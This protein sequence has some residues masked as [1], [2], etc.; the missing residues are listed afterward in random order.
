MKKIFYLAALFIIIPSVTNAIGYPLQSQTG[1]VP[2]AGNYTF[3]VSGSSLSVSAGAGTA[4]IV[5]FYPQ[6]YTGYSMTVNNGEFHYQNGY[7]NKNTADNSNSNMYPTDGFRIAGHFV[8]PTSASGV[9]NYVYDGTIR[10]TYYFTAN[11]IFS[12]PPTASFTANGSHSITVNVGDS[13]SYAWSSTNADKFSSTYT[14]DK[15]GSGAWSASSVSGAT[16]GII[17]S[18]QAGCTYALTYNASQISTGAKA[19]DA[20]TIKILPLGPP[21]ASFTDNGSHSI[22]VNVGDSISYAWSS[23]N[24]DK[25]SSTYTS[26]KCGSGAWSASS[27]SGATSGII[28]SAQAGCTYTLVYNV[29]QS[30]TKA[31]ASDT[32]TIVVN[33]KV[34]SNYSYVKINAGNTVEHRF[35]YVQQHFITLIIDSSGAIAVRPHPGLDVNG[36]GSSLYMQPFLPGAVLRGTN[37]QSISVQ[38]SGINVSVSGIVSQGSS[39]S[40]GTWNGNFTFSYSPF[41]KKITGTG[42]YNISLAGTLSSS[43]GDL[44]LYKL[45]SNY[46]VNVPLLNGTVGNTGDI[47]SV[48]VTGGGPSDFT[49]IPSSGSTYPGTVRNPISVAAVGDYNQVDTAAQGYPPIAA[50]YKPSMTIVLSSSQS[51]LPLIFGAGYDQAKS[52]QYWEDNVGITPLILKNSTYTNYNFNVTFDSTAIAGDH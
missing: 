37:V 27:V 42:T 1:V 41:L 50:A 33:P 15:C 29:T 32:I 38:S 30:L 28:G 16:S 36:W 48:I 14:S 45:A 40:Y 25:F 22:T 5:T 31:K 10:S 39:A 17:G 23:T 12:G 2:N 46:L 34:V 7:V 18:A 47:S 51:G 52:Q 4:R 43:T 49:W 8:T 24:A 6:N 19:S 3:S 35:F 11:F 13:I 44:N 20:I 9:V 26:D 21:T